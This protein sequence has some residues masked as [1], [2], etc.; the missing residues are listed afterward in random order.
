MT[1]LGDVRSLVLHPASTTHVART[2]EQLEAAGIG[3]GLLRLSIGIEDVEDLLADLELG[4]RAAAV[5]PLV[6]AEAS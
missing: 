2:A 5:R 3:P 6:L 1:H 4:L